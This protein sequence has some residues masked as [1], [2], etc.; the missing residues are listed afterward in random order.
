[1]PLLVV[2]HVITVNDYLATRDAEWMQPVYGGFNS[3]CDIAGMGMKKNKLRTKISLMAR[4]MNL[5]SIICA[6]IGL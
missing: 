6:T 5:V 1:M 3:G 4:I 2:A